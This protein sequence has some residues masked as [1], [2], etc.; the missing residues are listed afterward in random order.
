MDSK[1]YFNIHNIYTVYG[2]DRQNVVTVANNSFLMVNSN[3]QC[4]L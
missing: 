1:L 2:M 3:V 4:T